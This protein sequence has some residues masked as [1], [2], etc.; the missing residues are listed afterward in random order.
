MD[1]LIQVEEAGELRKLGLL[2]QPAESLRLSWP[3]YGGQDSHGQ[4]RLIPQDQWRSIDLSPFCPDAEDQ[5]GIGMCASSGSETALTVSLQM[6]GLPDPKL[7]AGDLYRRVSGG[8]DQGS[9]PEDNL[10]ELLVNG[11]ATIATVPYLD[12]RNN[13]PAASADRARFRGTEAWLCPTANHLASA[14]LAGFPCL[15]GYW[16]HANDEPNA[17]GWMI[18]PS[19]RRGGHAVCVIGLVRDSSGNWG[20]KFLNSWTRRWGVNGYGV[21]PFNRVEDGCRTFSAWALRASVQEP[22]ALPPPRAA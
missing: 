19:G 7:S 20:F 9:L 22:G 14:V 6:A 5:D 18:R 10:E 17:E 3:V 1:D 15:I 16:H 11:I 8:R 2:E 21:L 12:W 4:P 13:P